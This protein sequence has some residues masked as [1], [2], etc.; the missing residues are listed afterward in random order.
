VNLCFSVTTVQVLK[1]DRKELSRHLRFLGL[2]SD[3]VRY[4]DPEK[5]TSN[6]IPVRAPAD[7]EV[8]T[9]NVVAG[10]VVD[11]KQVLFTVV[12]IRRMWLML[13]VA[14]ENASL[15]KIGRKVLFR[16]DGSENDIVSTISWIS[17][18]ADSETRTINV[19]VELSNHK[20][21]LRDETF[22]TGKIVLREEP[23]AIV[24]PNEAVHWEGCC[25][26][27][28]VRDRNYLKDGSYKVFHT[29]VVRPGVRT[30]SHTEI[31]AGLLP[32]EVIVT[33]GGDVLRAELLKGDLGPG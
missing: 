9:R 2:P 23:G 7:G 18:K 30:S 20:G 19:R 3:I 31:I 11:T 14:M 29:R 17:T 32:W 26:V 12:D 16:P 6:L 22:G 21:E 33:K 25:H 28:F 5:S 1:E 13:N 4:L 24:V 27:V 8:V 10:E 15:L